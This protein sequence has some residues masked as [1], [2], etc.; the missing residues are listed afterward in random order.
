VNTST[1]VYA[2]KLNEFEQTLKEKLQG[3]KRAALG[4]KIG[5]SGAN[6]I[7]KLDDGSLVETGF[8]L[9]K[10]PEAK[11]QTAES[12]EKQQNEV[13]DMFLAIA[14]VK[15]IFITAANN[16]GQNILPMIDSICGFPL[17]G[18]T[19]NPEIA[20]TRL[21]DNDGFYSPG[22]HYLRNLDHGST[23]ALDG[24][25]YE[26]MPP[27]S[28]DNPSDHNR[29]Y[30]FL[31]LTNSAAK[32]ALGSKKYNIVYRDDLRQTATPNHP[33]TITISQNTTND[34][35]LVASSSASLAGEDA[36]SGVQLGE[37]A[38]GLV[39]GT[40]FNIG[41]CEDYQGDSK[42]AKVSNTEIGATQVKAETNKLVT[43]LDAP[44]EQNLEKLLASSNVLED[45][46]SG[47]FNRLEKQL[48]A[49]D[50]SKAKQSL[51]TLNEA[52]ASTNLNL[53]V[54]KPLTVENAKIG[55]TA[56]RKLLA[57]QKREEPSY[58]EAFEQALKLTSPNP[59]ELIARAFVALQ[60]EQ[61]SDILSSGKIGDLMKDDKTTRLGL[62]GSW[63]VNP[64]EA[65]PNGKAF[66]LNILNRKLGRKKPLVAQ[67]LVLFSEKDKDG[68]I[69]M[70][71]SSL[72]QAKAAMA[73][74]I[75]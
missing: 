68:M 65:L 29:V 54:T 50:S 35:V 44:G 75:A 4:V 48:N 20:D 10:K 17:S 1:N 27:G 23:I 26:T 14:K 67:N 28:L 56:I 45:G 41:Y 19:P 36:K 55:V 57:K 8:K 46:L 59:A 42:F 62:T 72:L 73:R 53:G 58:R 16:V 13:R 49:T 2:R 60:L 33:D 70:L 18:K 38:V 25:E 32:T 21:R 66:F 9:N 69:N 64:I 15:E 47:R 71:D 52:L 12:L 24:P 6:I 74:A 63:I 61:I 51:D 43:T 34:T 30:N 40:G 5:G 31:E 11:D 3:N 7:A 39:C 22:D 37:N